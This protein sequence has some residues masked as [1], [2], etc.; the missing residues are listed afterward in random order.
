[1]LDVPPEGIHQ[2]TAGVLVLPSDV[3][4]SSSSAPNDDTFVEFSRE[5]A[6]DSQAR[7][8][9]W[10]Y[11][12]AVVPQTDDPTELALTWRVWI[13]GTFFVILF[14]VP[15][16]VLTFR[17]NFFSIPN[18]VGILL[19]LPVG[20]FMGR[21]L[22]AGRLNPGPFTMKEHVLI[23]IMVGSAFLPLGVFNF[24]TQ[25]YVFKQASLS[26]VG[27][28]G[29][30]LGSQMVG[31][32]LAGICR[33]FLVRPASF[34]WPTVLTDVALYQ[35][36][37]TKRATAADQRESCDEVD[38]D[39]SSPASYMSITSFFWL[40]FAGAA[41]WQW[42]PAYVAPLFTSMSILCA[43]SN[44]AMRLWGSAF[45]GRGMGL[46][47][48]TFDWSL[49][50]R[51]SP[52]ESPWWTHVCQFG[53][54][55]FTMYVIVPIL[56][57]TN[58]FGMDQ[59]LQ[60]PRGSPHGVLNSLVLFNKTGLP[61][62]SER[63]MDPNGN[64]IPSAYESQKPI[65][66]S[67]FYAVTIGLALM[68]YVAS[69]C[70]TLLWYGK[71][72]KCRLVERSKADPNEED[73]HCRL[74]RAYPDI[75]ALWYIALMVI[76]V[77]LL[78]AVCEKGGFALSWWGVLLAI[79]FAVVSMVPI[80]IVQAI[81]GYQL[82]LDTI[83][84]F[85]SGLIFEGQTFAVLSFKTISYMGMSQA[86]VLVKDMKIAHYMKIPPRDMFIAQLYGKLL[87]A[88]IMPLI[89][90][91]VMENWTDTLLK[92]PQWQYV[93]YR[94]FASNAIIWGTIGTRQFVGLGTPYSKLLWA[95][96]LG[97]LLPVIPW[98]CYRRWGGNWKLV[99]VPLI[100]MI[101]VAPQSY[102]TTLTPVLVGFAS[103]FYMKRFHHRIWARYN[104]V[105]A[106][107][108]SAG[109]AVTLVLIALIFGI[110]QIKM[111][112]YSLNPSDGDYCTA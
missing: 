7:G 87:S 54:L 105:M 81:S 6:L 21:V 50:G 101:G 1:M 102:Q 96:P 112:R 45:P 68:A 13:I 17:T 79:A 22:P 106:A 29:F 49:I 72:I 85:I 103:N 39:I 36:L 65:Y 98:L 4:K 58:A 111:P 110:Q 44:S 28:L 53:G 48:I 92:E 100:T 14:A 82:P 76:S 90:V 24:V 84:L 23:S 19:T 78:I 41:I 34:F 46:L 2:P 35:T 91:L 80:G 89:A 88:I 64:L 95:L 73:I 63:A 51:W 70:H 11:I 18:L 67:T 55:Y 40:T 59:A 61:F 43:S 57:Y 69:I 10:D 3:A 26:L 109:T 31:Y 66:I 16:T 107:A 42:F 94:H 9:Y 86:L 25:K 97:A 108:L 93:A 12:D 62:M 5:R 33:Q 60:E 37:H 27:G 83:S 74:M 8:G 30:V 20:R 56:Y 75:P 77:P 71:D 15:N 32:G 38:S 99:N 52:L 104:Y 47:S